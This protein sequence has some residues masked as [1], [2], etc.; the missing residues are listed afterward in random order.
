MQLF[1]LPA[2]KT[3]EAAVSPGLSPLEVVAAVMTIGARTEEHH[4]QQ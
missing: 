2:G 1:I 3:A 4:E